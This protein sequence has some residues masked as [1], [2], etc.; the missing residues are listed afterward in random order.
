LGL[1]INYTIPGDI[2]LFGANATRLVAKYGKEVLDSLLQSSSQPEVMQ[3][4]KKNGELL[5]EQQV[6]K[7]Y[8][9]FPNA[10]G[11]RG[12]TQETMYNFTLKLGVKFVFNATIS[13]YYETETAAGIIHQGRKEEV[14]MVI[15]ADGIHSY[16][17]KFVTGQLD[18]A[19]KS[20][21]A[22]FRAWFPLDNLL[23]NPKTEYLAKAK[24][25]TFKIWITENRHAVFTTNLKLRRATAFCTHL[26][27]LAT[28]LVLEDLT[29]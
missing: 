15:V 7:D 12:K 5:L 26:V 2:I 11:Y 28:G 20:G 8:D 22:I 3:I 18:K 16:G 17:R 14:D 19:Q 9:G 1:K 13:E 10:Y 21:F 6:V 27:R 23:N 4:L 25:P 24:T 29:Y